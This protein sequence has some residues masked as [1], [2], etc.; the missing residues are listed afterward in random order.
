MSTQGCRADDDNDIALTLQQWLANT[1]L[2]DIRTL[3]ILFIFRLHVFRYSPIVF[4]MPRVYVVH[5]GQQTLSVECNS[6]AVAISSQETPHPCDQQLAAALPPTLLM[7]G[8][9]RRH[10][11]T[12]RHKSRH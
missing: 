11:A 3:P 5:F 8:L 7:P 10:V 6:S 4:V 9:R 2:S 1:H 12:L